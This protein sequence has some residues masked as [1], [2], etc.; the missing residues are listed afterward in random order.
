MPH[1]SAPSRQ[2]AK[3]VSGD[4]TAPAERHDQQADRAEHHPGGLRPGRPSRSTPAAITIV[5][6]TWAWSTSAASPGGMP[7]D[8]ATYRKPNWPSDMNTPTARMLRHGAA[9]RG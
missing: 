8:M 4:V 3:A 2:S 5:K 6:T 9:G 7:A 1:E